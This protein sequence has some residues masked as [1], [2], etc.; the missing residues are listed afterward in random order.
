MPFCLCDKNTHPD[1]SAEGGCVDTSIIRMLTGRQY[2]TRTDVSLANPLVKLSARKRDS[3]YSKCP[4]FSNFRKSKKRC[5]L[6][7]VGFE[8][9]TVRRFHGKK[10]RSVPVRRPHSLPSSPL[11][12]HL[13]NT[14]YQHISVRLPERIAKIRISLLLAKRFSENFSQTTKTAPLFHKNGAAMKN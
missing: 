4:A 11:N 14:S 1:W 5:P 3:S 10:N 6:A 8:P 7:T 9:T 12:G 13:S 2:R